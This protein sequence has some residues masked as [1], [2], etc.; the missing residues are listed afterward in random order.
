ME[1]RNGAVLEDTLS[2]GRVYQLSVP[3]VMLC[4]RLLQ[5]LAL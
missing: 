1:E 2:K 5:H 4:H 3:T